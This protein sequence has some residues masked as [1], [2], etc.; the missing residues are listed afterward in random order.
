MID[1][2]SQER[3]KKIDLDGEED[4]AKSVDLLNSDIDDQ[5]DFKTNLMV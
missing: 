1:N 4:D 2:A 3:L 5:S